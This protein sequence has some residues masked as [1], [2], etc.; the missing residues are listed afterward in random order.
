[1]LILLY[2]WVYLAPTTYLAAGSFPEQGYPP[3]TANWV[4]P[5]DVSLRKEAHT[6]RISSSP[7][8]G[9]R[10]VK[11][12]AVLPSASSTVSSGYYTTILRVDHSRLQRLGQTPMEVSNLS[13][14]YTGTRRSLSAP[15][16]IALSLAAVPGSYLVATGDYNAFVTEYS[17]IGNFVPA[18][19]SNLVSYESILIHLLLSAHSS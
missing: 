14:V 6:F 11:P 4:S 19:S 2:S 3:D 8:C 9:R 18:V 13:D 7:V 12:P 1:M 17:Y 10:T 5:T 16:Q 15:A